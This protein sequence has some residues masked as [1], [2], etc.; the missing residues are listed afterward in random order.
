MDILLVSQQL[1]EGLFTEK[2]LGMT[3]GLQEV[4]DEKLNGGYLDQK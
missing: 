2:A 3:T 4:V 1:V